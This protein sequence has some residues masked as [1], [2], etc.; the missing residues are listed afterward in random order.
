MRRLVLLAALCLSAVVLVVGVGSASAAVKWPAKCTTWACVNGHLNALHTQVVAQT[1][2]NTQQKA[3]IQKGVAAYGFLYN[4]ALEAP[5]TLSTGTF[6]LT[7]SGV[8]PDAWML[9]DGCNTN[10]ATTS[11]ASPLHSMHAPLVSSWFSRS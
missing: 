3:N 1:K 2:V 5:M 11:H 8:V 10:A 7:A 9:V 4:C 6:T